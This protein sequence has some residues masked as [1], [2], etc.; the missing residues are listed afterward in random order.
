LPVLLEQGDQEVDGHHGVGQELIGSHRDM[1][2]GNT[3]A[4]NLLELELD[5]RLDISNLV[6]EIFSVRDRSRELAGLRKTGTQE[7]RD[8]LDQSVGSQ[9]SVVFLGKLLDELFVLV[10]LLQIFN[11]H[12]FELDKLSTIDIGS[13][14]KNA[15]GHSWTGNMRELNSSRE[16]LVSLRIV[17]FQTDLKFD[18]LNEVSLLVL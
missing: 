18:S 5:G 3:H 4:Q 10:E 9:E 11:A 17:I 1:T 16:T 12:V 6:G 14:S 7:T 2:D 13:I 15:D 8:L